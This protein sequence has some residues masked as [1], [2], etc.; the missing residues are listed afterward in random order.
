[1]LIHEKLFGFF[2]LR[3]KQWLGKVS[4]RLQVY[5]LSGAS[6][7]TLLLSPIQG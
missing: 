3:K 5:P 2:L 6:R 4:G 7:E 1:M